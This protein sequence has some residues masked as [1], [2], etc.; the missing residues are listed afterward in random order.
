MEGK[1]RVYKFG[2]KTADGNSTM[3]NLLG[4]KGANLAEMS[5][6]GIPVPAGFTITTEVCTEYNLYGKDAVVE[7]IKEQVELGVAVRMA[8][9]KIF[10]QI[11]ILSFYMTEPA[12]SHQATAAFCLP[13]DK[14]VAGPFS[15][16]IPCSP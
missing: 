4:G 8:C 9:L 6:I 5:L 3:K 16:Y 14:S 10:L 13:F 1:K 11:C 2:G 15:S 12:R 7:V